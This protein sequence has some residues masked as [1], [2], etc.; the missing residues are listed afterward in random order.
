MEPRVEC[1]FVLLDLHGPESIYRP[2]YEALKELG[3]VKLKAGFP[4]WMFNGEPDSHNV[5]QE[6]FRPLLPGRSIDSPDVRC[7]LLLMSAKGYT[8]YG[9]Y[10][11]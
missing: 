8:S 10:K 9:E 3:A 1:Y 11:S 4:V 5:Y 6:K 7:G 2:L